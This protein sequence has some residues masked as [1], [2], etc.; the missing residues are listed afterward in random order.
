VCGIFIA[1]A[2]VFSAGKP[3]QAQVWEKPAQADSA[4]DLI[5]AVNVLRAANG[6]PA[7]SISPIL[8]YTAQ[9]QADFMA[10]TGVVAHEGPGGISV[11]DR[12]LA[13]GYPLAG[14]LSLGGLRSENITAEREG[15]SSA[16]SAVDSWTGDAP[17]LNTMLSPNLTE[18]GAG[19]AAANGR[20]F[21]VIDAA[22]PT[23]SGAPQAAAQSSAGGSVVPAGEAAIPVAVVNTPNENGEVLYEVQAGQTLWQIAIAYGVKIDEI[24]SLNNLP[25]NT[26]YPGDTLLIRRGAAQASA[27]LEPAPATAPAISPTSAATLTAIPAEAFST[28]IASYASGG[29]FSNTTIMS[30]VIGL[31]ALAVLAAGFFAWRGG[32]SETAE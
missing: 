3:V 17:H 12:L 11:T 10:A 28:P 27:T 8:M 7:Y 22:R 30:F 32:G 26:I 23:T 13:A 25:D 18:I 21:Y 19:V 1:L 29:A 2:A 15:S 16:Q 31:V 20:V 4:Y 5:N 14:D 24:K 6:L 9:A